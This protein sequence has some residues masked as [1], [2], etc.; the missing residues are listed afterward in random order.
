MQTVSSGGVSYVK[1]QAFDPNGDLVRVAYSAGTLSL[2]EF[3][4]A[5]AGMTV[6]LAADGTAL[7]PWPG[8]GTYSFCALDAAGNAT[9][10]Y[11]KL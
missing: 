1:V 10:V 9:V 8:A 3:R 7:I 4:D 2:T 11:V 5:S 6:S